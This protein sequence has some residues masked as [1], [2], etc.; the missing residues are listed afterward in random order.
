[1]ENT[2]HEYSDELQHHGTKGMK[3]G[4]RLYQAKDGSLT[5]LGRVRYATDKNFRVKAKRTASLAKARATREAKKKA[6]EEAKIAA[7]K[8]AKDVAAGKISAKKMTDAELASRLQ[9]LNAEKQYKEATLATSTGKRVASR[10]FNEALVPGAI[11]AGKK[12]TNNLLMKYGG[13]ALG[14]DEKEVKTAHEKL[15]EQWE[16]SKWTKE[17]LSNNKQSKYL[18]EEA[19]QQKKDKEFV[20]RT[21][22]KAVDGDQKGFFA[23]KGKDLTDAKTDNT[24]KAQGEVVSDAEYNAAR[25]GERYVSGYLNGP[26]SNISNDSV[27]SGRRIA[28]QYLDTNTGWLIEDKR[29]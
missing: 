18:R 10:L 22:K 15:K 25:N 24:P 4:V 11:E 5:P 6:E 3:W 9:R 8:R 29:R 7:E 26:V 17:I 2:I 23:K 21:N 19:A 20:D 14:L 16:E 12:L 28:N 1:M 27:S 13:K